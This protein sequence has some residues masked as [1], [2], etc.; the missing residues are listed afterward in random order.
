MSMS[1]RQAK[2]EATNVWT[3]THDPLLIE[4]HFMLL[5]MQGYKLP[6]KRLL[7]RVVRE[8]IGG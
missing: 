1:L 7:K 4:V 5:R 3:L 8:V 6:D 2:I